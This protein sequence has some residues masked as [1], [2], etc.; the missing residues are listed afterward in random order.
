M[1][2]ANIGWTVASSGA[3]GA[4]PHLHSGAITP[5]NIL[6][7]A[8]TNR[9]ADADVTVTDDE[10]GGNAWTKLKRQ[11]ADTNGSGLIYWKRTVTTDATIQVDVE[12]GTGSTSLV[13][14]GYTGAAKTSANPFSQTTIVGEANASGNL[15]QAQINVIVPGSMIIFTLHGTSNDTLAF[16]AEACD[17]PGALVE[18]GEGLSSTGS[19]CCVALSDGIKSAAGNTGAFTWTMGT[20]GT[21]AS[22]ACALEPELPPTVALGTPADDATGVSTTPDLVFTGTDTN[23]DEVEYEVQVCSDS[24]F[25]NN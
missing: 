25:P 2:I 15:T 1:A 9:D 10:T 6:V 19:D 22:I 16:G 18:E 7:L 21:T 14:T 4:S 20:A 3:A 12:G 5:N 13:L 24:D 11:A 17:T 8:V 23:A